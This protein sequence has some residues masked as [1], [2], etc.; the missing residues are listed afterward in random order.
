[1]CKKPLSLHRSS[2]PDF[3]L[4]KQRK[5]VANINS[6]LL[7]HPPSISRQVYTID[8]FIKCTP[9]G[10]ATETATSVGTASGGTATGR[11]G[12]V[13]AARCGRSLTIAARSSR[14]PALA[15]GCGRRGGVRGRRAASGST[16]VRGNVAGTLGKSGLRSLDALIGG[17]G[18]RAR[19]LRC[20]RGRC[21]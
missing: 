5:I 20:G 4:Q 19:G 2:I 9:L 13:S 14:G 15:G 16:H 8:L 6:L 1:M 17:G 10:S 7:L 11:W 12:L 3:V 18:G 21:G